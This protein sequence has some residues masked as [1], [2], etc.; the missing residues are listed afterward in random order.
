M[1]EKK[2]GKNTKNIA[3]TTRRYIVWLVYMK[4]ALVFGI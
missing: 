3:G 1:A 4:N 2:I